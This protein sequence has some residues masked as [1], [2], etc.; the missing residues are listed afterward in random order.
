MYG[1]SP[2]IERILMGVIYVVTL[3]ILIIRSGGI[4][5]F[6]DMRWKLVIASLISVIIFLF[7]FMLPL[8]EGRALLYIEVF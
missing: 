7:L 5:D 2:L 1:I 8:Y 4:D 3:A 6:W